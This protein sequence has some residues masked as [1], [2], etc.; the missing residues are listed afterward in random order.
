MLA[1]GAGGGELAPGFVG[2]PLLADG[3]GVGVSE[4]DGEGVTFAARQAAA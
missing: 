2:D 3:F 1:P 4:A